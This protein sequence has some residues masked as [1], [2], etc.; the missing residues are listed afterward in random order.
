MIKFL[1]E[2][3]AKFRVCF[4]RHSTFAWFVVIV[5]GIMLRSDQLGVTSVIRSLFL[6]PCYETMIGFFRSSGWE[7]EALVSKWCMIVRAYAPLVLVRDAVVMVGDGVKQAKEGRRMPGVKKLHQESE[8]CSKAEYIFGH[9]FGAI[10]ILAETVTGKNFCIPL[11]AELQDGVKT[12]FGWD[13]QPERQESHVVE[14][15]KLAHRALRHF[16]RAYLLLDRLFLTVPAL[17]ALG[18]LN[19]SGG[20]IH[21]VTKAKRNCVAYQDPVDKSGKR[22]RPAKKGNA[23]QLFKYFNGR[24]DSFESAK[25]TLYGKTENVIYSHAD[26]LWGKKLYMRLRFVFVEYNGISSILVSTDLDLHPLEIVQLYAKRFAI[27][28]TFREMKQVVGSF[29]YRFWSKY[30]PKLKR[31]RK[32][33]DPDPMSE[34]KHENARKRIRL[35]VKALEGYVFCCMVATGLL[36][37]ISMRIPKHGNL[38]NIRYMRTASR[39]ALSES[40]VADYL[41]QNIFALLKNQ[42]DLGITSIIRAKQMDFDK[43]YEWPDTG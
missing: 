25:M 42:A 7:L 20:I 37:M 12:I 21:V 35:A 13:N 15:I 33:G 38:P 29:R 10:G 41:R 4:S 5:I 6:I 24:R 23:V 36:Q 28:S 8:N 27:E 30:M 31:Y 43:Q 40:T 34:V 18:S 16:G 39:K 9:H 26:L 22:G 14:M 1:D 19:C 2:A 3:L 32:K 11:A 17:T